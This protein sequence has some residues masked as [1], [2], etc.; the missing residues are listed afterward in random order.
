MPDGS[1]P[2]W[3]I[4][5]LLD[6]PKK[7]SSGWEAHCPGPRHRRG[8][9]HA[10]LSI[11]LGYDGRVLLN[12]HGGCE[13][14]QLLAALRLDFSD[15][16]EKSRE[17]LPIRRYRLLNGSGH[18]VA[19]HV[20]Q[21][22]PNDKK[23]WWE[24]SGKKGLNGLPAANLPLYRLPDLLAAP[25]EVPVILTEGEKAA[26]ALA[27]IGMLALG[28]VAGA[29]TIPADTVLEPLQTH[30]VWL[31]PDNDP[32][33]RE[34]MEGIAARLRRSRWIDWPA[35]PP[36]GDAAD[37]VAAGG[38]AAGIPALLRPAEPTTSSGP[39][40][41]RGD[42]LAVT[43]FD[44]VRWAIPTI[45]PSG[46]TILAGRPKLGKSWLMLG[47]GLD[48]AGSG[49]PVLRKIDVIQG[50]VLYLAL[51]DS[52]RRMQER[53]A[54]MLGDRSSPHALHIATEWPRSNEGGLDLLE[55][56]I[57]ANQ[58]ARL[59]MID[60]FKRFRP[61][62]SKAQRLY[63]LDY[64]A[65]APLHEL[66]NRRNV[67]IVLVFHTN[68]LDPADPIDLVSGTL[69]LSGAADGVL[70]LKR[71]RGQADAS[72]FITG[73][74]VEEQDLAL[75]WEK[76]DTLGW[77]L[78]GNADDFRH[79]RERQQILDAV[80]ALPGMKP[81][82]IAAAI[83]KPVGN[84]RRLLFS[85]TNDG[86]VRWRDGTY[87]PILD[88]IGNVGNAGNDGTA[89]HEGT[90][91]AGTVT[92]FRS[93]VTA[94]TAVTHITAVTAV[95]ADDRSEEICPVHHVAFEFHNCDAL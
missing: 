21:E 44:P 53:Q 48:V 31:W 80:T 15:L 69:G 71:E 76:D 1:S 63:D 85:M 25:P 51:E 79:S 47:W 91:P 33:G 36:T 3:R 95:T 75:K 64:D 88:T 66:A 52:P 39:R 14:E 2:L 94:V 89:N 32:K 38:T 62:E 26:Q 78:L 49:T 20:R 90:S 8:D 59:V 22:L 93:P 55:Q 92:P 34:H 86:Q 4:L 17:G 77:A 74:D 83:G 28:T 13:T 5:G 87:W 61:K 29:A 40:I 6:D 19:E 60:T 11:S 50:D 56:W 27:D 43:R 57:D 42:E 24:H 16:F 68:K 58:H 67:A 54:M 81:G 84:V 73:R 10:S 41:W 9:K 7:S 37:Y 70:V 45:L 30:E 46:L 12:C 35:A 18:V 23:M 65:I 82:D 72:L